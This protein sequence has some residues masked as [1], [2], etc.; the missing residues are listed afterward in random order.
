MNE[1]KKNSQPQAGGLALNDIYFVLFRHKW[2]IIICSAI[3]LVAAVVVWFTK[4]MTYYSEA[5]LLIKYVK[6]AGPTAGGLGEQVRPVDPNG[7]AVVNTEVAILGSF[8]IAMVVATN[9]GPSNILA[10]AGGGKDP[11]VAAILVHGSLDIE[12]FP[13]SP[14]IRVIYSH[15]DPNLV[16]PI[17]KSIID[18]YETYHVQIHNAGGRNFD[19]LVETTGNLHTKSC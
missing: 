16:K 11:I 5:N 6:D 15:R 13:G 1:K 18:T 9:I 4:P 10:K 7:E 14:V 17:L 12:R 3:G 19:S 2:K 8:N